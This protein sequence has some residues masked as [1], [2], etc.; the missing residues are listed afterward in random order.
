MTPVLSIHVLA[1]ANSPLT[2]TVIA[3]IDTNGIDNTQWLNKLF[4]LLF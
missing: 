2:K 1:K 4:D 3:K